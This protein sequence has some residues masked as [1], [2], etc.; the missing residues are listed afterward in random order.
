MARQVVFTLGQQNTF[1]SRKPPPPRLCQLSRSRPRLVPS[2]LLAGS[3]QARRRA[4]RLISSEQ[5]VP[6]KRAGEHLIMSESLGGSVPVCRHQTKHLVAARLP[7]VLFILT[8]AISSFS[9]LLQFV[10]HWRRPRREG[11]PWNCS[12]SPRLEPKCKRRRAPTVRPFDSHAKLAG[13]D[14][15][16]AGWLAG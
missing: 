14:P 12:E 16:T 10:I 15:P 7:P 3:Q 5:T 11:A 13:L 8:P 9:E 6:S 2:K 1:V 4:A